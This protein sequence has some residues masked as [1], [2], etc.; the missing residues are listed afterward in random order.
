MALFKAL[1]GVVK[2][3]VL[4]VTNVRP[5][6]GGVGTHVNTLARALRGVGHNARLL[7]VFGLHDEFVEISPGL[8]NR[9]S[10]LI[11]SELLT[12]A[13]YKATQSILQMRLRRVIRSLRI[14][15]IHCHDVCAAVAVMSSIPKCY[16]L[17][18]VLTVHG[19]LAKEAQM[20]GQRR[21]WFVSFLQGEER[22]AYE[23]ADHIICVDSSLRDA[24]VRENRIRS[25]KISVVFN[26]VDTSKF[27]PCPQ[28]GVTSSS[29]TFLVPRRLVPK[30]GVRVAIEAMKLVTNAKLLIAGDGPLRK[31]LERLCKEIGV[32]RRVQFLGTVEHSE[33]VRIMNSV[34]GVIIPSVPVHGVTEAT[35]LAALEAMSTG[36]PVVASNIGGLAE[37]IEDQKTGLL[38]EAG[39]A[40]DLAQKL[41]MLIDNHD[42]QC[43]LG[44]NAREAAIVQYG[45]DAWVRRIVAIYERASG[46]RASPSV[47]TEDLS[48]K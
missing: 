14:D 24:L 28:S 3:N 6:H 29:S 27:A 43:V 11:S 20:L 19:L 35:S 31:D 39:N 15:V 2:L 10:P 38:F 42:L 30:N 26:A 33:M 37:I 18:V 44:R 22:R 4:L 32:E 25:D 12:Y 48:T 16:R 1:K 41:T 40:T 23:L 45:T 36:K 17:P 21:P 47:C 8:V 9:A 5:V 7:T 34:A 46:L 13:L